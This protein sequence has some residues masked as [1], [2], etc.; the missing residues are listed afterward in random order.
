MQDGQMEEPELKITEDPILQEIGQSHSQLEIGHNLYQI[1]IG[2]NLREAQEFYF[3]PF[4]LHS[5]IPV[6][7]SM[8]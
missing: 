5:N 7:G 1:E 2:Q 6:Q 3:P 4:Q 8:F